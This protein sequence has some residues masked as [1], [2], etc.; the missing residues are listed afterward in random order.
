MFHSYKPTPQMLKM[1]FSFN[2]GAEVWGRNSMPA[3]A[4]DG[5]VCV[6]WWDSQFNRGE[7]VALYSQNMTSIRTDNGQFKYYNQFKREEMRN[8]TG[9]WYKFSRNTTQKDL[10]NTTNTCLEML[11]LMRET[12]TNSQWNASLLD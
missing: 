6:Q 8:S 5:G 11:T 2:P 7:L 9:K 10:T 12:I 3:D 1:H 4:T